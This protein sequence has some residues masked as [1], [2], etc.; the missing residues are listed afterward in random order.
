MIDAL[1][2]RHGTFICTVNE[3]K[4]FQFPN[5][6]TLASIKESE[7]RDLGFGYRAKYIVT[8]AKQVIDKGANWLESLRKLERDEVQQELVSLMGIGPKVADCIA[9]FS[10]DKLDVVPVDTHVWQIAQKYLPKLKNQKLNKETYGEIGNFFRQLFGKEAGWAH[11]LLFA[12]EL[13]FFQDK[14]PTQKKSTKK[15][16]INSKDTHK[17][18]KRKSTK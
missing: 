11:S 8:A 14:L 7:L 18:K 12:A 17:A 5:V 13:S 10:L 16:S 1:C 6:H 15:H 4:Y 9:L 3:Q 2:E